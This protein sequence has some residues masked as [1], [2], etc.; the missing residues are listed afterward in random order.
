VKAPPA[1]PAGEL[2]RRPPRRVTSRVIGLVL[3]IVVAAAVGHAMAHL[4][5]FVLL[6]AIAIAMLCGRPRRRN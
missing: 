4:V 1:Q 5:P 6:A 3:I 2:N